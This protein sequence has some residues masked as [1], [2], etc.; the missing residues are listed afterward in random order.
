M[1]K[2]STGL[3]QAG[4][5]ALG[6]DTLS[7]LA[8]RQFD[9]LVATGQTGTL[10]THPLTLL[11][12]RIV[13]ETSR[14]PLLREFEKDLPQENL[15]RY[16]DELH[17]RIDD[18]VRHVYPEVPAH[19][20]RTDGGILFEAGLAVVLADGRLDPREVETL[21]ELSSE[22]RDIGQVLRT[23]QAEIKT[24]G[25]PMVIGDLIA[26]SVKKAARAGICGRAAEKLTRELLLIAG[27]DGAVEG[28]ELSVVHSFS[29]RFGLEM[30]NLLRMIANLGLKLV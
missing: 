3:H 22:K 4:V 15:R 25:Q 9:E 18:L 2:F 13:Q 10:S 1:L 17:R 19:E 11:R 27:S 8:L 28:S 6:E 7:S 24:K 23:I 5:S 16:K 29:S 20:R 14:A 12:A 21:L 26:R 30:P